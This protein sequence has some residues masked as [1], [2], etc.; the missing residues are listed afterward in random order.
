MTVT[1]PVAP[2][3]LGFTLMHEHIFLSLLPD[4]L[5]SRRVLDDPEIA[6]IE[7]ERYRNAGGVTVVDQTCRGLEQDPAAVGRISEETGLKIVLGCGWYREPFY[8][9]RLYR[10]TANEIADEMIR[11]IT[12]GIDGTGVRAGI[13]GELGAHATWVSP[14]EERVLRAGARAHLQTGVTI[15]TH[16][17]FAPVGLDQLDI[18]AEEGVDPR[19]VVIGHAHDHPYHDYH[20]ELAERGAFISFD[21]MDDGNEFLFNRDLENIRKIVDAGLIDHLLLSHD[22]CL[23]SSYVL[24]GGG[25]Y[26][27]IS[28]RL[29]P[30]LRDIGITS[31]Q[32]QT[33]MVDNPRRAPDRR[34]LTTAPRLALLAVVALSAVPLA[35]ACDA[36]GSPVIQRS[37]EASWEFTVVPRPTATSIPSP[38]PESDIEEPIPEIPL[39]PGLERAGRLSQGR[40]GLTATLLPD[41]SVAVVGGQMRRSF[42]RVSPTA[43]EILS[44]GSTEWIS[45]GSLA[46]ERIF[47]TA[48]LLSDGRLLVAGGSG[49]TVELDDD[50]PFRIRRDLATVEVYDSGSGQWSEAGSMRVARQG[51]RAMLL[52]DGRVFVA[53][54]PP[55]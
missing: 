36:P 50:Q 19:R 40:W 16:G 5:D 43:A 32:F 11:D 29:Y 21:G 1:G 31:S 4:H 18:L 26:E 14:A 34:R 10:E 48:T 13:I 24:G 35:M 20:A 54:G 55:G 39:G 41:D 49:S 15:T 17:L 23:K 33:I 52:A 9:S 25:G 30:Y 51:A 2:E 37:G 46:Y 3:H 53:G 44:P 8:E 45:T 22:V 42:R 47:H 38:T 7:L 27:F 6:R 12:E 28:T